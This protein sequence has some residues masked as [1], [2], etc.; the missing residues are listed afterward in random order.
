MKQG[1]KGYSILE[2]IVAFSIMALIASA[3]SMIVF[4]VIEDTERSNSRMTTVIQVQNAGQWISADAQVAESVLT[5]NLQEP[6]FLILNWTE[7]DYNEGD[8]VYHTITYFFDS[9]SNNVG[10]LKRNHWSS[11][12]LNQ[13]ALVAGYIYYNSADPDNTSKASYTSPVLT[14]QLTSV[15]GNASE[16]RE[17]R[18]CQRPNL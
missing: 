7:Q 3:V 10:K 15:F 9:L 1:E 16:T 14:I 5:E 18:M 13:N 6:N 4:R 12:G 11:A 2:L 8:P 17:Y